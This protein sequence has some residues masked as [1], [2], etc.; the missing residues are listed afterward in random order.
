MSTLYAADDL[1][2]CSMAIWLRVRRSLRIIIIIIPLGY[3]EWI[4]THK[5]PPGNQGFFSGFLGTF[6]AVAAP[7][8][9]TADAT[10]NPSIYIRGLELARIPF[11]HY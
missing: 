10:P 6:A 9:P 1:S 5:D 3:L 11:A 4:I 8:T 2:V 7:E